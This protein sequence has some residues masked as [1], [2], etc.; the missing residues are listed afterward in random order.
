MTF[1]GFVG[2]L[3]IVAFVSFSWRAFT[4]TLGSFEGFAAAC[5]AAACIA[6]LSSL[7]L[8]PFALLTAPSLAAIWLAA[9]LIA[10][11]VWK[12]PAN[13][14]V[15]L[16]LQ[17]PAWQLALAGFP[18]IIL[19]IALCS[20]PASDSA[21]S[22][23]M[24]R[25]A[26]WAQ[27]ASIATY[28]THVPQQAAGAP[29]GELLRLQLYLLAG[30]DRLVPLVEW[31]AY[32]S[33]G[34]LVW[35][36]ANRKGGTRAAWL[37]MTA[38][39]T[40]PSA[41]AAASGTEGSL[42][43]A[44]FAVIAAMLGW[45]AARERSRL[46]AVLGLLATGLTLL[47]ARH[48]TPSAAQSLPFDWTR[49]LPFS[50]PFDMIAVVLAALGLGLSLSRAPHRLQTAAVV[51]LVLAGLPSLFTLSARPF[52]GS[53]SVITT[54]RWEQYFVGRPGLQRRIDYLVGA[55]V[56]TSCTAIAFTGGGDSPEYLIHE[57][58]RRQGHSAR[59]FSQDVHN[60]SSYYERHDL[61]PCITLG[62]HWER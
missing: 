45:H 31:C 43:A 50:P 13:S 59:I 23:T 35:K 62:E 5:T 8:S 7:A 56:S 61:R 30:S 19:L 18:L 6:V 28:A 36:A 12:Q 54:P 40:A 57:G 49:L 29:L 2:L 26:M 34:C 24:P 37:A 14:S 17:L 10:V 27:Q 52:L 46:S 20:A 39:Y 44:A 11:L 41:I 21:L 16:I 47:A 55:A 32:A 42:P 15:Y 25:L 53:Q 60:S 58:L 38:F 4:P 1:L 22:V 51:L 33:I 3:C 9:A 48:I